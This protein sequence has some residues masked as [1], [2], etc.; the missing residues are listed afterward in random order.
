MVYVSITG[1][2]LKSIW[3][4][5]RFLLHAFRSMRQA[6]RAPGLLFAQARSVKGVQHTLT[7]WR[8]RDDMRAF[9]KSGAHLAAMQN[10]REIATGG[11]CGYEAEKA[12][13]WDEALAYW[14]DNY[15]E[16]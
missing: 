11:A 7:V 3:G 9:L 1:L 10:F 12:P 14:R 15:R 8:S 4:T 2:R 13:S 5:P 16:Y 6:K